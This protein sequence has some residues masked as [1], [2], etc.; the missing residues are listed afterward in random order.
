MYWIMG[1]VLAASAGGSSPTRV[2]AQTIP[3]E[4]LHCGPGGVKPGDL[5]ALN[6][7][8]VGQP[9]QMPVVLHA[10][11]LDEEGEPLLDQVLTLKAGQS[12]SVSVRVEGGG[13]VRGEVVPVSGPED[14]ALKA[15]MQVS[16]RLRLTD[17]QIYL[18]SGLP[19]SR[20]PA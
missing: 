6:V 18:C 3:P 12:R 15:T 2:L 7:G 5:V 13:P 4:T 19:G 20:P 10:R 9:P 16:G 1:L 17:Q 8:N 11:V 14:A